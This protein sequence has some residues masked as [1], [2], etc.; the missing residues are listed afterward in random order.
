M[1][2][3]EKAYGIA[4]AAVSQ[5]EAAQKV[6]ELAELILYLLPREPKTI[7]EIGSF[8]GGTLW[9]FRQAFPRAKI[10][11]ID[12]LIICAKCDSRLAHSNCPRDRVRQNASLY[13]ERRSDDAYLLKGMPTFVGDSGIDFHF[14]DGDHSREAVDNDFSKYAPLLSGTGVVA[15]HDILAPALTWPDSGSPGSGPME[16]WHNVY[17]M[18]LIPQAFQIVAEPEEWG[19]IGVIPKPE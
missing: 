8:K 17:T 3:A 11:S 18:K 7:V 5:N 4:A 9:A 13:L 19:G 1:T 10:I 14:I 6:E 15:L 16:F 12:P 2:D